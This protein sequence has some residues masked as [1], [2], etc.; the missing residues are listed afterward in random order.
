MSEPLTGNE[1]KWIRET[2]KHPMAD[3]LITEVERLA[4]VCDKAVRLLEE[5]Q[6]VLKQHPESNSVSVRNF[7][8]ELNR[9]YQEK[10]Q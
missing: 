7:L 9:R 8:A 4:A 5:A 1:R 2:L 6:P 3:T 10:Y